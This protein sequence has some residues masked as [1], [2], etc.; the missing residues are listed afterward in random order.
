MRVRVP[1]PA[2]TRSEHDIISEKIEKK[3][4]LG[5]QSNVV[6]NKTNASGISVAWL[7]RLIWD[8]EGTGSNPVFRTT[9]H[10]AC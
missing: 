9:A 8:Q 7:S 5:F 2:P 10:S 3:S 1:P 6:Y 4:Y